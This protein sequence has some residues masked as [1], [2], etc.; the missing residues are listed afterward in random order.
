MA[1]L[2]F[3]GA[4]GVVTGSKHLLTTHGKHVFV[5]CG[6]FQG[7]ADVTALNSAPL[8]IAPRDVDAVAITHGH[9][10]HVGYLPK[11]V[12]DGYRGSIFCTPPT[13]G[14][15]EIVLEDAAHLQTHL[16]DRGYH[17]EAGALPPLY[18]EDDV[19]QV[20]RQLRTVPLE[21]EFDVC[22]VTMRY[23]N[24][25]HILGSAFVDAHVEGAR[26][27]FSGDLGRYGR[28]LL[29]DPAP[30]DTADVVVMEAT[31]GDRVHPAD[32]LGEFES[33]LAAGIARGGT[34]VIPAFAVERT[35]DILLSIGVLQGTNPAIAAVPVHLD[36][37]MAIKVDALFAQFPDAHKPIPQ[38]PGP[39]GC[40]NLQVYVTTDESKQLNALQGPAIVIAS[41]GMATGGRILHH[42]HNHLGD[43][44]ATILVCG[45]QSPGTLGNLLVH[46]CRQVRIF[47]DM[48]RVQAA[49]VNLAGYSAHADQAELLRWLGTLSSSPRVY[50]VH[51][52]PD[53]VQTFCG[54]VASRLH[55]QAEP[56]ERGMTVT[57]GAAQPASHT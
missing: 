24:A 54:V 32:P 57:I 26:V 2:T 15:I 22:G 29:D 31:Y 53:V 27:I 19:A 47:G 34:I 10:D 51:G 50:A 20:L 35:Q 45:Y 14:L 4:A 13:A 7:T 41:S 6:L 56:A 8:P 40:R 12:R 1:D 46:G 25:G 52:D 30:L 16:H 39:F 21:T 49:I 18:D 44:R 11:L 43:P 55:F 48:L 23:R 42:L 3:V 17:R 5:D 36:S 38:S 28:P 37:P 9:L 33:A